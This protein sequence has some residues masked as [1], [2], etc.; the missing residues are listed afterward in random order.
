MKHAEAFTRGAHCPFTI[1][2]LCHTKVFSSIEAL[3]KC[4]YEAE[5]RRVA[6]NSQRWQH[7]AVKREA[8]AQM[9][10]A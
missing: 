10:W 4:V 2:S 6:G 7:A 9:P 1:T 5:V 3:V 8:S